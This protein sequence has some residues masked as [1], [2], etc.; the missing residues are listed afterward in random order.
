MTVDLDRNTHDRLTSTQRRLPPHITIGRVSV[1]TL[2]LLAVL[3]LL[4]PPVLM[5]AQD[6]SAD[7]G[8]EDQGPLDLIMVSDVPI[9]Y[10]EERFLE[11]IAART[12]GAREPVGLV[13]SGGSARAFAHIGVLKRCEE[14]GIVPDFI[15]SNSMGSIVGLLYGAG[16]SPDDIQRIVRSVDLGELFQLTFPVNGGLLDVSRFT[17]LVR[18]CVGHD[19]DL[20]ELAI[21]VMVICEDLR[22]KQQIR[23]T[24]GDLFTVL[25]AAYA[26][27]VYF[28]PVEYRGH[29]LIDGGVSNLVPLDAAYAISDLIIASTTFYQNPDLNLR[30]PLT[31]LNVAMD[32]GKSRKGVEQ[33]K[34]FDP[35]LIRCQVES[36]SFMDFAAIDAIA[37]AGYRS[38]EG[39]SEQLR[40][41]EAGG[42]TP[43]LTSTRT[44]LAKRI[45][46]AIHAYQALGALP[47]RDTALVITAGADLFEF[48]QDEFLLVDDMFLSAGAVLASG[49]GTIGLFGGVF[50]GG[51][52]SP[53]AAPG[54]ELVTSYDLTSSLRFDGRYRVGFSYPLFTG[55]TLL[56]HAYQHSA[57]TW[58]PYVRKD[59]SADGTRT[60]LVKTLITVSGETLF[61][62]LLSIDAW[63]AGLK[64]EV[65][66][67]AVVD[68]HTLGISGRLE[69]GYHIRDL[70]EQTVSFAGS[71]LAELPGP[72][73]LG[74]DALGRIALGSSAPSGVRYY[75]RDGFRSALPEGL[76]DHLYH[77]R[78]QIQYHPEEFNPAF[79]ELLIIKDSRV[80]IYVDA[81]LFDTFQWSAGAMCS[82]DL[83]LIGL[84]TFRFDGYSGYDSVSSGLVV[85]ASLS[86]SIE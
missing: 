30:N 28:S 44:K 33:I 56:E 16:V 58:V 12:G 39:M 13:L 70:V 60:D 31:I 73:A 26:L 80:G 25:E 63:V 10:G 32:V 14:L 52:T 62:D 85:G 50:M 48:P 15:I 38:A 21:P 19:I 8:A 76:Y 59:I 11:R 61:D 29:L 46:E 27:P 36:F 64:A 82:I 55:G 40:E 65:I 67:A 22:T 69:A 20:S 86:T 83:S 24:E 66:A 53:T 9:V 34:R 18:E 74:V 7:Q 77:G 54:V 23:I 68:P 79:A 57:L 51:S 45:G 49:N 78:F 35:L 81:G 1:R 75:R 6:F 37:F 5:T 41:V 2:L 72:I 71:L 17:A 43:S 84:K 42:M 4:A 47:I 3:I